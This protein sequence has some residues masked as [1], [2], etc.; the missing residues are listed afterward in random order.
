MYYADFHFR[1]R[2]RI[3]SKGQFFKGNSNFDVLLCECG[4]YGIFRSEQ[5]AILASKNL[6]IPVKSMVIHHACQKPPLFMGAIFRIID[7]LLIRNLT[8]LITV[9][10]ATKKTLSHTNYPTNIYDLYL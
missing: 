8:S 10:E 3:R 9:S 2:T 6:R 5:A 1:R 4:N 7:F